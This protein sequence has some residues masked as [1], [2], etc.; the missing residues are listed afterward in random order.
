MQHRLL[1]T[2]IF[3][4][5]LSLVSISFSEGGRTP[6]RVKNGIVTSSSRLA[7]EAGLEALKQG[8]NAVDAAVATAFALAVSWPTAGN[9]GGGGFLVYHGDDGH[10]TTFDFREKAPLA[11]TQEMYLG[12]DGQVI[13]NSN[14]IGPLA[15][16][17]PGT[18]AG[19]WKAH[20]ELGSLPWED[21]VAPAIALARDGIPMSYSLY[22]GFNN[23][24]R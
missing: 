2:L 10:A 15:V 19:L 24:M 12:L 14:H 20:Q 21:L 16:G 7:S 3:F 11:A 4:I 8:G 1:K 6:L 23:S 22:S 18:V 17:V 9:I 5:S 13:D